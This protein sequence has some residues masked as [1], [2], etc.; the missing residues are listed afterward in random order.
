MNK[1]QKTSLKSNNPPP[2]V[3]WWRIIQSLRPKAVTS[4]CCLNDL[5]IG[6]DCTDELFSLL[7]QRKCVNCLQYSVKVLEGPGSKCEELVRHSKRLWGVSG[8]SRWRVRTI[9]SLEEGVR[10]QWLSVRRVRKWRKKSADLGLPALI[11]A[12]SLGQGVNLHRCMPRG[13]CLR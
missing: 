7:S 11:R 3:F 1:L 10:G 5:Q 6:I 2:I 4:F 13:L 8:L 9:S 12:W